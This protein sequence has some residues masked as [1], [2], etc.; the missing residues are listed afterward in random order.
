MN[1][2]CFRRTVH[3]IFAA[4]KITTMS[5]RK[6]IIYLMLLVCTFF[7]SYGNTD[8]HK[9][10]FPSRKLSTTDFYF[11]SLLPDNGAASAFLPTSFF[12]VS[13]ENRF[14]LKELMKER[15]G[16]V[17]RYKENAFLLDINH[18]GYDKFGEMNLMTGYARC[19]GPHFTTALRLYYLWT[20]V[21]EVSDIHSLTFDI[22]FYGKIGRKFALG[23]SCYNPAR[24]KYG[25]T[26][27]TYL[28]LRFL[29]EMN[30]RISD[31]LLIFTQIEKELKSKIIIRPGLAYN[32]RCLYLL[33]S[34]EFPEPSFHC[35]AQIQQR[36]FLFGLDCQYRLSLGVIP[37]ANLT[38]LF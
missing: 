4:L 11:F 21:A 16:A 29:F 33:L 34:A 38:F 18:F 25:F 27:C 6:L 26:Q 5:P 22:S 14:L 28:P 23:F 2:T 17:F 12:Y 7:D 32:V 24:L 36:R 10:P 20:H 31:N 3:I 13:F 37:Q 8:T 1:N 9:S 30:Y 35:G 19:F 15:L